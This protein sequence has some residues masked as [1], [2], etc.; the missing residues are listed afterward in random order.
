MSWIFNPWFGAPNLY[1]PLDLEYA[2]LIS[3]QIQIHPIAATFTWTQGVVLEG[4][5]QEILVLSG[6]ADEILAIQGQVV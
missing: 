2:S 1:D 4:P 6:P 3:F 5:S